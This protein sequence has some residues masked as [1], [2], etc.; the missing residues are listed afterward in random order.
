MAVAVVSGCCRLSDVRYRVSACEDYSQLT[1]LQQHDAA[2]R[3]SIG[4]MLVER[5]GAVVVEDE[6]TTCLRGIASVS[7]TFRQCLE[8]RFLVLRVC[9]NVSLSLMQPCAQTD[10][11]V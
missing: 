9:N 1:A 2:C 3:K 4:H 8:M 7:R 5:N 11:E 6:A 10:R